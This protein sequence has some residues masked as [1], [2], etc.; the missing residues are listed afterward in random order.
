[1]RDVL[2]WAEYGWTCQK[3]FATCSGFNTEEAATAD[4]KTHDCEDYSR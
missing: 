1:M 2:V 3:C 4:S